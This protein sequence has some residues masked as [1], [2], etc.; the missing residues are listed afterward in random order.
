MGPVVRCRNVQRYINYLICQTS[1]NES[2]PVFIFDAINFFHF[3][4]FSSG[5]RSSAPTLP[6]SWST[7]GPTASGSRLLLPLSLNNN[8][9]SSHHHHRR[10]QR[11]RLHSVFRVRVSQRFE[12]LSYRSLLKL[13]SFVG[14]HCH[15]LTKSPIPASG[16]FRFMVQCG[17]KVQRE[18]AN[19]TAINC[20]L[21]KG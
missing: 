13:S 20:F 15:L 17:F 6:A 8:N 18:V 3:K 12:R 19:Q 1:W 16:L 7:S 14:M 11:R 9:S 10:L 2:R 4:N 21:S 5:V